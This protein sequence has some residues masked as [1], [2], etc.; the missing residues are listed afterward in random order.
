MESRT[1]GSDCPGSVQGD[2]PAPVPQVA[3]PEEGR[4]R[5][6]ADCICTLRYDETGTFVWR[7]KRMC[8]V[9]FTL[10][11]MCDDF[12]RILYNSGETFGFSA[13][14]GM[15]IMDQ[16]TVGLSLDFLWICD[17]RATVLT[18]T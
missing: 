16:E 9:A 5:L 13:G 3:E 7:Y 14:H 12:F 2:E 6:P 4:H 17:M 18:V 8:P 15:V 10:H 1:G 11:P